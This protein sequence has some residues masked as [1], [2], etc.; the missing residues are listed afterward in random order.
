MI[1]SEATKCGCGVA[2]L[3]SVALT[4]EPTSCFEGYIREMEIR[5]RLSRVIAKSVVQLSKGRVTC[6][7]EGN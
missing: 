1:H 6:K 7:S 2:G 5:E 4:R 3:H